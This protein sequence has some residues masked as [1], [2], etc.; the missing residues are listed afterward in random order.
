M[1]PYLRA[2][3]EQIWQLQDAAEA[4]REL[5]R[6]RDAATR[7]AEEAR[8]AIDA[9]D[10]RTAWEFM[11]AVQRA[12]RSPYGSE[13]GLPVGVPVAGSGS[14]MVE[15]AAKLPELMTKLEH[16]N[17][18]LILIEQN[19]RKSRDSLEAIEENTA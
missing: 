8:R 4:E 19:I 16:I 13:T 14:P 1:E 12:G 11:A 9:D 5:T 3:Q 2:G 17:T 15:T 6:A 7:A 10:F 18:N